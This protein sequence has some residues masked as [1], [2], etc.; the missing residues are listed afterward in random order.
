MDK[1]T[2]LRAVNVLEKQYK[3][4][5]RRERPFKILIH[6]ILSTRTKDTTTFPAQDRLLKLAGS[7]EAILKLSEKQIRDAIYPVGFYRTKARLLKATCRVLLDEYSGKVP[8]DKKELMKLPG[9]GDKV[10]SLVLVW[11]FGLPFIP[12]DTHV[13]RV[14]QRLGIV[15]KGTKPVKIEEKLESITPKNRAIVLNHL[16]VT[17]GREI[18][19]PVSPLCGSCPVYELC[20]FSG[21]IYYKNKS[22]KLINQKL[23][24]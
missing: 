5:P 4:L 3:I 19:K 15:Q 1:R 6:G 22:N 18:C 9:V 24:S 10:A 11:G 8:H 7:P 21:K 23:L 14:S 16:L 13:S 12:V 17:F 20:E 2:F